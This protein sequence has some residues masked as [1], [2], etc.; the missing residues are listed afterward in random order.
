MGGGGGRTL[1]CRHSKQSSQ[2]SM[3]ALEALHL[4]CGPKHHDFV[5]RILHFLLQ[6]ITQDRQLPGQRDHVHVLRNVQMRLIFSHGT[7]DLV[8]WVQDL[9]ADGQDRRE[10]RGWG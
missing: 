2:Q 7:D 1:C 8:V 4:R 5:T 6:Y 9:H 3:W 10:G